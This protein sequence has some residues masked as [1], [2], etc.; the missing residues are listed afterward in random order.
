MERTAL[1]VID[2][3]NI[4]TQFKAYAWDQVIE[5]IKKLQNAC[6]S[7]GI[8]VIFIQ[9][10]DEGLVKGSRDW[11]LY[12]EIAPLEGERVFHKSIPSAFKE[13]NLQE[14]LD[15]KQ[16]KTLIITGLQTDYCVDTNV[17]VAFELGYEVI[18]PE[19]TNTTFDNGNLCAKDLYEHYNDHVFKNRFSRV[20][21]IE[22]TLM[23]IK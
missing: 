21:S 16:Y 13:T 4:M 18:T 7:K 12:S 19:F 5:N 8:E 9:H 6:R 1:L 17:K 11:E 3:Q 10:H 14:Y 2:V 22:K 23:Q 20:E 15:E